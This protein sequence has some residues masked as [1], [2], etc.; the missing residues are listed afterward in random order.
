MKRVM[1]SFSEASGLVASQ[2]K[3]AV[4][5]GN[6]PGKIQ[7]RILQVTGFNRGA[8]PFCNLGVPITSKRLAKSDCDALVEKVVQRIVCLS[9]RHLSYAARVTLVNVVLMSLYTYW[10]QIFLVPKGVLNKIKQICRA[11]LWEGRIYSTKVPPVAREE[12]CWSKR[13]GVGVGDGLC[14][15][16]AAIGKYV[17]QISQKEDLIWIKWIHCVYVKDVDWWEYKA[18]VNVSWGWKNICKIKEKMRGAY[19]GDN[20]WLDQ[21][22]KYTIKEGYTWLHEEG[23]KVNW[24]HWV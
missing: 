7:E 14:W 19:R 23:E 15:N 17:W 9:S 1:K 4:Y 13:R 16:M 2:E 22:K 10:A 8:F 24:H 3:T 6:V 20:Q 5:F 12:V 21:G 11:F 18:P